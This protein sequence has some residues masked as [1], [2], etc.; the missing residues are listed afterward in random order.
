MGSAALFLSAV[1][2]AAVGF[3]AVRIVPADYVDARRTL[4]VGPPF[5]DNARA[6]R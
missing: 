1:S 5:A 3:A 2:P 6:T 4:A